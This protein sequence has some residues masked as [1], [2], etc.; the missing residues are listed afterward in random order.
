MRPRQLLLLFVLL[1]LVWFTSCD[2]GKN[3]FAVTGKIANMPDQNVYLEE[4][5]INEI[6]VIDSISAKGG[7]F[8]LEG[9][10]PEAGLYRLRFEKDKFI[11]LSIDKGNIT[12]SADWASLEKYTVEGSTSSQSLQTFLFRV[13]EQMRD[14]NTMSIII[15]SMTARGNDSAIARAQADMSD[16]NMQFTRYIEQYADTTTYLPNALFAVQMLNPKAEKDYLAVFIQSMNS[17][18][19]KSKLAKD[20]TVKFNEIIAAQNMQQQGSAGASIGSPAPEISLQTPEGKTVALSSLK[21]KYVLVDFWASWCGPCRRE[22]PNVVG[23][24]NKYKSKNFDILGVSLDSDKDKWQD[25]IEKDELTWTHISDLQGWESIAARVYGVQ[26][27][28][29][30]FL[31]D[32]T[33]VIIA[34]DLRAEALDAKL[35]EVLK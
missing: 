7:V 31:V 16:M 13:R 8:E 17:R 34:R 21:G 12:V 15:D 18:F 6:V 28:P 23:A 25:A 26:S 5:T 29:A 20:F 10:A 14:F 24:Y 11:L 19:P 9:N 35:A 27:I 32:P 30:N 2:S 33:G 3:R 22:N 1:P 4:L